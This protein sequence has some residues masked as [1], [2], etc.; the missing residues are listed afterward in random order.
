MNL[1]SQAEEFFRDSSDT[2]AD[3]QFTRLEYLLD[4]SLIVPETLLAQMKAESR[5]LVDAFINQTDSDHMD[6]KPFLLMVLS[7]WSYSGMIERDDIGRLYDQVLHSL[8]KNPA[9]IEEVGVAL[10]DS[11]LTIKGVR[12]AL[13]Y[14]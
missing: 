2:E 3:A 12:K 10:V 13:A 8:F 14:M 5:Q 7:L 1:Y 4:E 11:N 6:D 9:A